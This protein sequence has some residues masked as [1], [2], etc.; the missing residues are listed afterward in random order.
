MLFSCGCSLV[1][2]FGFVCFSLLVVWWFGLDGVCFIPVTC[3]F[4]LLRV[5][6]SFVTF[7]WVF[8]VDFLVGLAIC[9]LLGLIHVVWLPL[10]LP[11]FVCV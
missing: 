8:I 6:V 7:A 1:A 9:V 2:E 5:T 4:I 3:G 11:R 10:D